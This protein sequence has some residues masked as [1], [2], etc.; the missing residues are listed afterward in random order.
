MSVK[1]FVDSN[2]ILY[3]FFEESAKKI[4]A[5]KL[6]DSGNFIISSQVVGEVC[7]NLKKKGRFTPDEL[8]QVLKGLYENFH[9]M[10]VTQSIYEISVNLQKRFNFSFWD[11]VI[12]ASALESDCEVLY[13]EDMQNELRIDNLKIVNPLFKQ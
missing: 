2:I 6:L 7:N 10:M 11:S 12:V 9:V 4:S 1:S 3:T 13:S 5:E 8:A